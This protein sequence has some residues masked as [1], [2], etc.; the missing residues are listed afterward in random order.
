MTASPATPALS[1]RSLLGAAA[2]LPLTGAAL[3]AAPAPVPAA[4]PDARLVDAH[5]HFFTNDLR[6]YPVDLR[7]AREPEAVMQARIL[8][9]PVT[10]E[11][12]LPL[13]S[14]MGIIGGLGVQY[15]GAYKT[16][17]SYVLDAADAHPGQ[18]RTEIILN[19]AAPE[20]V[21]RLATLAQSRHVSAIRLTGFADADGDLPWLKSPT[22]LDL[23][24]LA[25]SLGLPIGI[26]YLRPDPTSAA[27]H[28][29]RTLADRFPDCVVML[30][31][32]GWT[33][34]AGSEDGLLPEHLALRDHANIRFKWTTL[35]I[36]A[37]SGAGIDPAAFLRAA[38]DLFGPARLMWG[39][40]FGNTTR[41]YAGIVAD[42]RDATRL[43][44]AAEAA[45]VLGGTA[46]SLF[47]L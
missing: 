10:P 44:N 38:V 1:R 4:R 30:E 42:A 35:N 8:N 43:L 34:G 31:H 37:L 18:I 19:S 11:A 17:N 14:R 46:Q 36:D 45:A 23:W 40:D 32:L 22:A 20:S 6:H 29:I 7:N 47:R 27:L 9:A 25:Q 39:S 3:A 16:D 2:M 26:T 28:T 41:P 21:G 15:S 33:G 13:W 12:I 24:A 5:I